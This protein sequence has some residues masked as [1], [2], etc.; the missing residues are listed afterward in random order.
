MVAARAGGAGANSEL[1]GEFGLAGGG[2]RRAFFVTNADPFDPA[3]A[4][5]IRQR[6]KGI[7]DQSED[8]FDADLLEYTDQLTRN[9]LRHVPLL[10]SLRTSAPRKSVASA[11]LQTRYRNSP[12]LVPQHLC[13]NLDDVT[14]PI[15]V[16]PRGW[17]EAFFNAHPHAL[18]ASSA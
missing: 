1:T 8:A 2:E 12:P 10:M 11:P 17:R 18:I 5:R 9:G 7:A 16:F 14:E 13:P 15:Q 6:I 4:H 3:F